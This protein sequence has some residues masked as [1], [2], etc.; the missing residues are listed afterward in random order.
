MRKKIAFLT[1]WAA[2]VL[3]WSEPVEAKTIVFVPQDNRPVSLAYTVLTAESAGYT[4]LTP[5][6]YLISGKNFFGYPDEIWKWLDA[7]KRRKC[8]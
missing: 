6:D 1:M 5:P 3:M 4:V 7:K 2:A 8:R